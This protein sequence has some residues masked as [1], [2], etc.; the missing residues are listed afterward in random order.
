MLR[1]GPRLCEKYRSFRDAETGFAERLL[2][3]ENR[4]LKVEAQVKFLHSVWSA[5]PARFQVHFN[6]IL[7]IINSKLV[8]ANELLDQ[9]VEKEHPQHEHHLAVMAKGKLRRGAF[10]VTLRKSIDT[11]IH[12]LDQWQQNLLDPT[13]YQLVL[14]PGLQ[15]QQKAKEACIDD[16]VSERTLTDLR[17][18]LSKKDQ[19]N[20]LTTEV[21]LPYDAVEPISFRC[22]ILQSESS[23]RQRVQRD[24]SA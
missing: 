2:I 11:T 6:S 4:W 14:V 20:D 5:L 19:G 12:D 21:F 8:Q 13:W 17:F 10:A 22:R 1:Y 3:F 15:V 7:S 23:N 24:C 18:L 16:E 9:T